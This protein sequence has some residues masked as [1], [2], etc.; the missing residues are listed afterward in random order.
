VITEPQVEAAVEVDIP[1]LLT[2]LQP[3]EALLLIQLVRLLETQTAVTPH[4]I[5]VQQ[6]LVVVQKETLQLLLIHQAGLAVLVLLLVAQAVLVLLAQP[7]LQG[8]EV[9]EVAALVVLMEQ[10][11]MVAMDLEQPLMQT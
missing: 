11:V 6:R 2:F 1:L 9:V 3:Q 5:V 10:A 7:L 4:G 8:M